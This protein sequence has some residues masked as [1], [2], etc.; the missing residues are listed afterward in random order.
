M[1]A[2]RP[3]QRHPQPISAQS[4][5]LRPSVPTLCSLY[6]GVLMAAPEQPIAKD[7]RA[8]NAPRLGAIFPRQLG[9]T[10]LLPL[11]LFFQSSLCADP[12]GSLTDCQ[13]RAGLHL[14]LLSILCPYQ[15][16]SPYC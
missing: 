12:S 11:K 1:S 13:Q 6:Q 7:S 2:H 5:R 15:L 9:P 16:L 4:S 10:V 14:M 3:G 8:G